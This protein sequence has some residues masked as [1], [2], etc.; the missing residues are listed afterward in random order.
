MSGFGRRSS[1][2]GWP[3]QVFG[4]KFDGCRERRH[5]FS[6]RDARCRCDLRHDE[7]GAGMPQ[8]AERVVMVGMIAGWRG[9]FVAGDRRRIGAR[10]RREAQR[11]LAESSPTV[12]IAGDERRRHRPGK[13][14][15]ERQHAEDDA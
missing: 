1:G 12:R 5:R 15:G 11:V 6:E 3:V 10:G 7:T 13:P 2:A 4:A 14:Q 8:A 9:Q